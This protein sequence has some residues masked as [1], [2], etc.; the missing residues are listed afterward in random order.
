M[1]NTVIMM[2]GGLVFLGVIAYLAWDSYRDLKE[3]D[4]RKS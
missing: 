2:L 1:L 3:H 4:T